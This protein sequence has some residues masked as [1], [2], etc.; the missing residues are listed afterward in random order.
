MGAAP[1][2]SRYENYAYDRAYAAAPSRAYGAAPER[3]ESRKPRIGVVLGTGPK[4]APA[5]LPSSVLVLARA[6]VV[7]LLV[8]AAVGLVR[9]F[10]NSATVTASMQAQELSSQISSARAQG[11]Q[12]EVAQ[13][14]L[15]NPARVKTEANA[16]GMAA[17]AETIVVNLGQDVVATDEAGNLS[18]SRTLQQAAAVAA[19][20]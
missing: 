9:V 14:S 2:Y 20:S 19:A 8:L 5:T 13:S 15:S 16:M 17:P 12:L 6:L 3:A 7:V 1:A 4:N 11:N 18:L 10:L